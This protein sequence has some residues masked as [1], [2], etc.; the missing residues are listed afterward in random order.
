MR[1]QTIFGVFFFLLTL[2]ACEEKKKIILTGNE[3]VP[4]ADFVAF[5]TPFTLPHTISD[6]L[7]KAKLGDSLQISIPVVKAMVPDSVFG[8]EFGKKGKPIF[9]ALGKVEVPDAE[10]YIFI[11]TSFRDKRSVW[12]LTFDQKN[13]FLAATHFLKPSIQQSIQQSLVMDR[14]YLL[15]QV[16]IRKNIDGS[17]SEGKEV[18]VFNTAASQFMLIMTEALEDKLSELINP[19]DTLLATRK[20]SADYSNGKMNLVSIRDGRKPDRISF[21]IHF[22]KRE[23]TK[24]TY[25]PL[26]IEAIVR[27]IKKFP[28]INCS[29]DGNNIIVKKDINVGMATALPS[30]NLIVPVIRHADQFNMVGL[31]KQVNQLA[32]AARQGKLR[33]NDTQNGTFTLTNVGTFGSLMGTPIINQPQV[34]ILAV[35]A[36]KKRPVVVETPAGDSIAIRHMMYLSMS[37]DHRIVDG[38]LGAT[39]L[40]AVA[41]ELE[42]FEPERP[43]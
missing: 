10:K 32:D 28:L 16:Q 34:A 29:L 4:A 31:A 37:Y 35:G 41:K 23:G 27:C 24:I 18:F 14:K 30:G 15:S 1:L 43:L 13:N 5:F 3:P 21:F 12:I 11:R 38:S 26:F 33:P 6:T 40:T 20:F 25:T 7:L 2:S 22:E 8:K 39:F 9:Y 17:A 42:S 19:I 36:I